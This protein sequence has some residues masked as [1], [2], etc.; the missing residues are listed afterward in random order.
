MRTS[1]L[2]SLLVACCMQL[3]SAQ[4]V[5]VQGPWVKPTVPG[6]SASAAFMTLSASHALT[7]VGASSP[8]AGVVEIHEM[9]MQGN[10]MRMA[11]LPQ[12]IAL[13]SNTPVALQPG[14]LHIML[15]D[16]KQTL[17]VGAEVDLSLHFRDAKGQSS[18]QTVK[19]VVT[20]HAPAHHPK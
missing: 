15:M 11:A 3:A 19:A 9:R 1:F 5:S 14:G 2:A 18:Q 10:V 13:P 17:T 12:G 7:L 4:T 6:Q 20:R 16:L 8:V